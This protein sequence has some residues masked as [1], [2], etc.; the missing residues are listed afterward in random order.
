MSNSSESERVNKIEMCG[1]RGARGI[2]RVANQNMLKFLFNSCS[3]NLR[4]CE[5]EDLVGARVVLNAAPLRL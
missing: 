5:F 1:G 4:V 2:K 3:N